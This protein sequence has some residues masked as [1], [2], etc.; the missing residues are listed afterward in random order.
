MCE[1]QSERERGK[2]KKKIDL[3]LPAREQKMERLGVRGRRAE[4]KNSS[5]IVLINSVFCGISKLST[6]FVSLHLSFF[7]PL[8]LILS[9]FFLNRKPSF[10]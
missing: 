5:D 6:H 9:F 1:R 2:V 8:F 4:V 3:N 10:R 7:K